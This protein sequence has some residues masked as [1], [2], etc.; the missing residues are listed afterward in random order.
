MKKYFLMGVAGIAT[1][2]VISAQA[3][4]D[5][6]T[7]IGHW[8][9]HSKTDAVSDF[10]IAKNSNGTLSI[11]VQDKCKTKNC[12]WKTAQ[13]KTFS[14]SPIDKNVTDAIAVWHFHRD[15]W[16]HNAMT[17]TATIKKINPNQL[18]VNFFVVFT[19]N[20][21]RSNFVST[22]TFDRGE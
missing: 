13:L 11:R 7:L 22:E 20:S 6:T 2:T 3:M 10:A 12:T 1:C 21:G 16:G 4:V 8:V 9:N 18:S 14:Q 15:K 19:D 17:D 5:N